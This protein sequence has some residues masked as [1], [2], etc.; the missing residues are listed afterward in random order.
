MPTFYN[1]ACAWVQRTY[2]FGIHDVVNAYPQKRFPLPNERP[3]PPAQSS[4]YTHIEFARTCQILSWCC[5]AMSN[6]THQTYGNS[7]PQLPFLL[8][9]CVRRDVTG[10][11]VGGPLPRTPSRDPVA[12]SNECPPAAFASEGTHGHL[13]DESKAGSPPIDGVDV[14]LHASRSNGHGSSFSQSRVSPSGSVSESP[15]EGGSEEETDEDVL[16]MPTA[17]SSRGRQE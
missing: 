14:E 13:H 8:M 12:R 5:L 1:S 17:S 11:G 2:D 6:R 16:E 15:R 4:C 10:Y 3:A 7:S 9:C